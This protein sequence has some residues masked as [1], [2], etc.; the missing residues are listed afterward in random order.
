M[1]VTIHLTTF[2]LELQA[3]Y[4]YKVYSNIR[5]LLILPF[6]SSTTN[7]LVSGTYA[8]SVTPFS[9]VLSP[10]DTAPMT[11]SNISLI[12]L[13]VAIGGVNQIS[14][15]ISYGFEEFMTQVTLY[16]KLCALDMGMSCGL[17]NQAWWENNRMYYVDLS[18][19]NPADL[20][21]PRNITLSFTNNSNVTI[22]VQ[23]FTEYFREMAIDVETGSVTM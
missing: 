10:F 21:T 17:I 2:L 9:Q 3:V 8:S 1:I 12:N 23:V 19:C 6:I 22:D 18:R 15:V 11:T 4:W 5:G 13:Q 20:L 16:E 14:N 7:G